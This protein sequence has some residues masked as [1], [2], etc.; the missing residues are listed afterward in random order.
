ML[1]LSLTM[2]GLCETWSSFCWLDKNSN[3]L[4]LIKLQILTENQCKADKIAKYGQIWSIFLVLVRTHN[5]EFCTSLLNTRSNNVIRP[6]KG[7]KVIRITSNK[8]TIYST[9][10]K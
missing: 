1:T 3:I 9:L 6:Q 2:A 8:V 4:H 5:A 7:N 10:K